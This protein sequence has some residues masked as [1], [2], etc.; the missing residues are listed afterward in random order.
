MTPHPVTQL[1]VL[2]RIFSTDATGGEKKAKAARKLVEACRVLRD[3]HGVN[4]TLRF[5]V[6][7]SPDYKQC[8]VG[9]TASHLSTLYGAESFVEIV[10]YPL[11]QSCG[12]PNAAGQEA[13]G[14]GYSHM[15]LVSPSAAEYLSPDN[16]LAMELRFNGGM[17]VVGLNLEEVPGEVMDNSFAAW[18]LQSLAD[19]G[20]FDPRSSTPKKGEVR[21]MVEVEDGEPVALAGVEE[22][23]PLILMVKQA[24]GEPCFAFID[25]PA[26]GKRELATATGDPE[27]FAADQIKNRSKLAR[28]K[29]MAALACETLEFLQT[30]RA[31]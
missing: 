10:E 14:R 6:L 22:V 17:R 16:Y 1:L 29:G 25:P 4:L 23:I 11:D 20:W 9:N 31:A 24:G 27:R 21:T 28:R 19:V 8:D 5:A 3:N 15:L 18:H 13:L 2:G 12:C 30:G 7:T 26:G